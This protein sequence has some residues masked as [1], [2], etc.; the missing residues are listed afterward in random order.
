MIQALLLVSMA[1]L[2]ITRN[3]GGIKPSDLAF[4]ITIVLSILW[5]IQSIKRVPLSRGVLLVNAAIAAFFTCLIVATITGYAKYGIVLDTDGCIL[6]ARFMMD[7]L[8]FVIIYCIA[9][10]NPT[11]VPYFFVALVLPATALVVLTLPGISHTFYFADRFVGF[12]TEE[13]PN[14][15]ALII[16]TPVIITWTLLLYAFFEK[17]RRAFWLHVAI[18]PVLAFL[19]WETQSRSVMIAALVVFPISA[20]AVASL[21]VRARKFKL[22][23]GAIFTSFV[24][25]ILVGIYSLESAIRI[26]GYLMPRALPADAETIVQLTQQ[27]SIPE[28]LSLYSSVGG[29][30]RSMD[31]QYFWP[32]ILQNPLGVGVSFL[33]EFR[34]YLPGFELEEGPNTLLDLPLYSGYAGI[35][36]VAALG[37]ILLRHT[38]AHLRPKSGHARYSVSAAM[39]MMGLWV[40]SVMLGMPFFNY[41]FWILLALTMA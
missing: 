38:R 19:L 18:L 23:A 25:I 33:Q 21:Y 20:Y 13:Q 15:V 2:P 35:L 12:D 34:S 1:L 37:V 17:R 4:G 26:V 16:N 36:C 31:T 6:L 11:I 32:I 30:A 3:L 39:A 14:V 29:G 9:R 40:A 41:E 28:L 8:L 22:I 27:Y 7:W 10:Q 24:A 5:L